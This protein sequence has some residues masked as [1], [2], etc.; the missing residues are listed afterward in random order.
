MSDVSL[1]EAQ[2]L[3]SALQALGNPETALV[4]RRLLAELVARRGMQRAQP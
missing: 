3:G 1:E 2:A 4:G